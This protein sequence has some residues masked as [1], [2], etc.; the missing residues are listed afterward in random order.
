METLN[1]YSVTNIDISILFHTLHQLENIPPIKNLGPDC[2]TVS[3]ERLVLAA[4]LSHA[5]SPSSAPVRQVRI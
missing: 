1:K 2:K 3:E 4:I 5:C